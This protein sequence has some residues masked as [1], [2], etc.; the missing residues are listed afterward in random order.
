MHSLDVQASGIAMRSTLVATVVEDGAV[1]LDLETKYFYM[2]N[3][4]AWAV[5][6][7]FES[8]PATLSAI[9][10]RCREWGIGS[11]EEAAVLTFLDEMRNYGLLEDCAT[12]AAI[13]PIDFQARWTRPCVTRQREPL[14]TIVTSAFDPSIPLAE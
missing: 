14:Q 1:L 3:G 5:A 9:V 13:P 6:Q 7:L 8:A 4:S 10:Q 12:S 2:L 11:A